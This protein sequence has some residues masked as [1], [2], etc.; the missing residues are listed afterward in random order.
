MRAL[1][2]IFAFLVCGLG[3]GYCSADYSMQQG[4]ATV[5][6]RSGPWITWPSAGSATADPYTRAH[7]AA[8]G[9]LPLTAFEAVSFRANSDSEGQLLDQDCEYLIE[10]QA[11]N[12]R[13]WS[14][15]AYNTDRTL[16]DNPAGRH[17]FNSRNMVFTAQGTYQIS[18]ARDP[19]PGNWL[20]LS[21]GGGFQLT[22]RLY[23]PDAE[24]KNNLQAVIMPVIKKG[25]CT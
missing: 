15:T 23:N 25:V 11:F 4:L 3:L 2:N 7:F 19:R 24:T 1:I 16:M 20:P 10:G 5:S 9:H 14:L 6:V 17:S 21:T 8:H 22:L 18:L 12:A 13:W